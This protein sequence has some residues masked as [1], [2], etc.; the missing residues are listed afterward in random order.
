MN[1]ILLAAIVENITTRR[2]GTMK[3]TIGTQEIS[4]GKAGELFA[5]NGKLAAVYVSAKDTIP[6]KELDQVDAVDVDLPGKT[7]SQRIRS[8]LFILY[9]QD[10]EGYKDFQSYYK[11]KTEAIINELKNNIV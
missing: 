2:D 9:E 10:A 5:L 3:V 7:Q 6:Q 4:Q 8:V 1:G 11:A